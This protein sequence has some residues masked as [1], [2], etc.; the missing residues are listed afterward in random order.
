MRALLRAHP[1]ACASI[2]L[3][4][5]LSVPGFG[6]P[7]WLNKLTFLSD[8]ALTLAAFTGTFSYNYLYWSVACTAQ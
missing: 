2:A 7:G 5:H 4:P 3:V 8:G 6:G 1:R